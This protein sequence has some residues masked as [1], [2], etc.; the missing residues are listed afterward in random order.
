[1]PGRSPSISLCCVVD[2]HP[3]F[4]VELILWLICVRRHMPRNIRPVVYKIG[5]LPEDLAQWV[6]DQGVRIVAKDAVVPGSPHS[7]KIAPF[8][9]DHDADYVV[10]TD[11]D[12]FLLTDF[13]SLLTSKRFRAA[14]NNH[15]NPPPAIFHDI[16]AAAGFPGSFRAGVSLFPGHGGIRETHVNNISAGIVVAPRERANMMA[17]AWRKW[18]VWLVEHRHLL[19]LWGVHVDQVAFALAMEE[20]GEDVE[21]LPPQT[22]TILHLLPEVA[23]LYAVHLT[24]GHI[25]QFPH[26]FRADGTMIADGM[27]AGVATALNRLN[28]AITEARGVIRALPSMRGHADKFLNPAWDRIS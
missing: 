4:H 7:N 5:E 21:H 27:Q 6:V 14:P 9:D 1:M 2:A 10:V 17:A 26:L 8:F 13:G 18:A 23:T 3:R 22:N 20:F 12:L 28:V 16:L 15:G 11:A 24:T 19:G 25:P